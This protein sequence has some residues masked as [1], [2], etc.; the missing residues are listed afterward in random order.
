VLNIER[1]LGLPTAAPIKEVGPYRI[2]ACNSIPIPSNRSGRQGP[3]CFHLQL[4]VLVEAIP[5]DAEAAVERLQFTTTFRAGPLADGFSFALK[6]RVRRRE[7]KS[8]QS[9]NATFI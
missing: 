4:V 5:G 3:V 8:I 2:G 1:G 6:W 7:W 9:E